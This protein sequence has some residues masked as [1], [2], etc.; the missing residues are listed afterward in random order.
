LFEGVKDVVSMQAL[1]TT[2]PTGQTVTFSGTVLPDKAGDVVYLQKLGRDGDFHTVEIGFVRNDS[3][4]Q[5]RWMVGSPGTH[6]FRARIAS[7]ENNI[8][9]ASAP[10]TITATAPA[11]PSLPP[12][13]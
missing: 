4:F 12:A 3:T 10:V 7:D 8:G 5:F 1:P 6:T 2:T 9:S 11:A 13:S